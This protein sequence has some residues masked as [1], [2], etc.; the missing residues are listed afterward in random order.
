MQSFCHRGMYTLVVPMN[1]R[2][3]NTILFKRES[4][5]PAMSDH[6]GK[7]WILMSDV[8]MRLVILDRRTYPTFD[9]HLLPG[10]PLVLRECVIQNPTPEL[11]QRS[12]TRITAQPEIAPRKSQRWNCARPVAFSGSGASARRLRSRVRCLCWGFAKGTLPAVRAALHG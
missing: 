10:G 5:T 2:Q 9:V 8:T 6:R 12:K 7:V 11:R 3:S 4:H 1:Q